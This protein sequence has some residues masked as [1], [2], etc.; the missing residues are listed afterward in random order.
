MVYDQVACECGEI[1]GERCAWS[2]PESETVV[3]EVMPESLRASHS[4][5]GNW[6]VYPANGAMRL[7][8]HPDCAAV[9]CSADDG[10]GTD[11]YN[12]IVD[13]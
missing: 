13:A 11:E 6:G 1:L 7:R 10:R 9:L 5:A 12:H 3:V 8:C 4:T 2:G